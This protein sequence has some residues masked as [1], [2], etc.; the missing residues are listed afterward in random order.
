MQSLKA[1]SWFVD[2]S[3]ASPVQCLFSVDNTLLEKKKQT[4][5]LNVLFLVDIASIASYV[6]KNVPS[7]HLVG[8]MN[9]YW[10]QLGS[11]IPYDL[12][13]KLKL[14]KM[15]SSPFSL[16]WIFSKMCHETKPG[17][18]SMRLSST[19]NNSKNRNNKN[20]KVE[21]FYLTKHESVSKRITEISSCFESRLREA[22]T[23]TV[24]FGYV[25]LF[26]NETSKDLL[27][28]QQHLKT[29]VLLQKGVAL[30]SK[31]EATSKWGV[32]RVDGPAKACS[33]FIP[34]ANRH[35]L[36]NT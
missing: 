30:P 3:L 6:C 5:I 29:W 32:L 8:A 20:Q 28:A 12:N 18:D 36:A 34:N 31:K 27:H 21:E 2:L 9:L 17:I 35:L 24:C 1:S 19:G 4:N 10:A 26:H 16:P 7:S 13:W 11:L 33:L 25:W 23:I 14:K 22:T 15:G